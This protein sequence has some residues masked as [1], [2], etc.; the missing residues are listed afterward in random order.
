VGGPTRP[1]RLVVVTGTG[2]EVGKTWVSCRL[3]SLARER[4]MTVA[5]RKPVQSYEPGTEDSTDAARLAAA[6]AGHHP[7]EAEVAE[8]CPPEL[9]YPVPLAPPMAAEDLGRPDVYVV[10]LFGWIAR[11]WPWAGPGR[12]AV[13]LGVVEGAGGVA[14]PLAVDGDTAALAAALPADLV[15]L[16]SEPGLGAINAVRLSV[17]AVAPIPVVVHLNR[18]DAAV[19]LHGRNA[20][21]LR[22]RDGFVVTTDV[23]ELLGVVL[24]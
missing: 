7:T 5:A 15:V 17:A 9:S 10:Q 8:V 2:T 16:V 6:V 12:P 24:A 11:S 13:E 18:F 23:A 22:E 21:W 4:G 20:L 3:L 14:S 1:D 19:D